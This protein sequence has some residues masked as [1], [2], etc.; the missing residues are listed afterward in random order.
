MTQTTSKPSQHPAR[1]Q[2]IIAVAQSL[3]QSRGYNGFS[4]RDIADTVGIKSASIHYH[5]PT[6]SDLAVAAAADYRAKFLEILADIATQNLTGVR[7][8]QAYAGVFEITLERS[9]NVCLCGVLASEFESLTD[10][11]RG[12]VDRFFKDQSV[13]VARAIRKGQADGEIQSTIDAEAFAPAYVS[14]LEGAMIIARSTQSVD[15]L[16]SA[17]NQY[18]NLIKV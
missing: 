17:A 11:V 14:G 15:H 6:K 13:W 16:R 10:D 9:G 3:I 18:L 12:E 2:E 8:L 1:A 5:F 4:F 7:E